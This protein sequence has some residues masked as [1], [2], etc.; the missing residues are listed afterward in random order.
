MTDLHAFL[1]DFGVPC[2][3]GTSTF[4]AILDMPTDLLA[5]GAVGAQSTEYEL[6]FVS[7]DV[8]LSLGDALTVDG[9][10]FKLREH[11][12]KVFDGGF[13]RVLLNKV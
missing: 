8:A 11:P 12:R 6:R 2:S 9:T 5:M 13:S 4:M 10:A 1:L 3:F 7:S